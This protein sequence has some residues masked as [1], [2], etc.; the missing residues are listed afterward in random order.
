M[1]ILL[2]YFTIS[3][4]LLQHRVTTSSVNSEVLLYVCYICNMSRSDLPDMYAQVRGRAVPES[5]CGHIRQIMSAH[6]T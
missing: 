1:H 4:V 3:N 5:K 2:N 6:V